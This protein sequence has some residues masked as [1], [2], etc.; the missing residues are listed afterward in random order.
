[1]RLRVFGPDVDSQWEILRRETEC[2]P[3]PPHDQ[4]PLLWSLHYTGAAPLFLQNQEEKL[5]PDLVRLDQ[6]ERK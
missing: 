6:L 3:G 1:M 5:P 4:P 2:S